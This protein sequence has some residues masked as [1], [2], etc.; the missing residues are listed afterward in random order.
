M[1]ERQYAKDAIR[2]GT[3]LSEAYRVEVALGIELGELDENRGGKA[4]GFAHLGAEQ[5]A[6]AELTVRL[7]DLPGGVDGDLVT[8]AAVDDEGPWWGKDKPWISEGSEQRGVAVLT[9]GLDHLGA[10][11]TAKNHDASTLV[12]GDLGIIVILFCVRKVKSMRRSRITHG[13]LGKSIRHAGDTSLDLAADLDEDSAELAE[14]AS[15][16]GFEGAVVLGLGKTVGFNC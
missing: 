11:R 9:V 7:Q 12:D 10:A 1:G 16:S 5:L 6:L 8:A 3:G 13:I 2:C 4:H 15:N 14:L